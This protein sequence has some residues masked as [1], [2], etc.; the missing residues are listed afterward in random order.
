MSTPCFH[1]EGLVTEDGS[2]MDFEG[3]LSLILQL[4]KKNRIEIRDIRISEILDQY[5]AYLD[6]AR[7]MNLDIASEF[8]QMASYLLFIKS[9]ML[10]S[11]DRDN[12]ELEELISSLEKLEAR[13][14]FNTIKTVIPEISSIM[15]SGSLYYCRG[16]LLRDDETESEGEYNIEGLLKALLAIFTRSSGMFLSEREFSTS[17]PARIQYSV[18]DKCKELLSLLENGPRSLNSLY[19]QCK[20]RSELVATF[21]SVLELCSLGSL[22]VTAKGSG[23]SIRSTGLSSEK[24]LEQISD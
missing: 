17:L 6:T 24:V 13:D 14:T 2:P 3:P 5:N 18:R 8:I 10:L 20:S 21:I 23:Y 19:S 7:E 15:S 11:G 1:L 4:L 16:P 9:K 22:S 12:S